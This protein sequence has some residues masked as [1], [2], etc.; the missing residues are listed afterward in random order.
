[1]ISDQPLS[2]DVLWYG[3]AEVLVAEGG[4]TVMWIRLALAY[5]LLCR[6]SELF[7]VR[8]RDGSPRV[9]FGQKRSDVLQRCPA[10]KVGRQAVGRQDRG[11][12]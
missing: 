3:K 5:V 12:F 6:A 7:C 4:G 2:W 9:L 11:L 8:Q 1:M 10:D